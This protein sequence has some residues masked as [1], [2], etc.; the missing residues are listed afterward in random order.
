MSRGTDLNV[1]LGVDIDPF[2]Q[3]LRESLR[4]A[5]GTGKKMEKAVEEAVDTFMGHMEKLASANTFEAA[6]RQLKE[7][8]VSMDQ[9]GLK[10]T[11]IYDELIAQAGSY[12]QLNKEINQEI[13]AHALSS[14]W[15]GVVAGLSATATGLTIV[16]GGLN[17]IGIEG[18]NATK[19][20]LEIESVM[21][22]TQGLKGLKTLKQEFQVLG[23]A[24]KANPIFFVAAAIAAVTIAAYKL[25]QQLDDNYQAQ[26]RLNEINNKAADSIQNEVTEM[27]NLLSV[28]K[29]ETVSRRLRQK[30]IDELQR[31]YP[32]YLKNINLENIGSQKTALSINAVTA[33]LMNKAK[34]TVVQQELNEAIKEERDLQNGIDND[35]WA[36]D[37]GKW[38][39]RGFTHASTALASTRKKIAGLKAEL[40]DLTVEG[41]IN[42][43]KLEPYRE[44]K[45]KKTKKEKDEPTPFDLDL[46]KLESV[47][48]GAARIAKEAYLQGK[49]DKEELDQILLIN[50]IDK[51][52]KMRE[53]NIQYKKDTTEL[54]DEILESKL[55]LYDLQEKA[56]IKA[57]KAAAKAAKDSNDIIMLSM[58]KTSSKVVED[59]HSKHVA[60]SG[61]LQGTTNSLMDELARNYIDF[62]TNGGNLNEMWKNTLLSG[63]ADFLT[64]MGKLMITAGITKDLFDKAMVT[65][66]GGLSAAAAGTGLLLAGTAMKSAMAKKMAAVPLSEG[67]VMR[68]TTYAMMAEYP[69]AN[70]DPEVALRS[71]HLTKLIEKAVGGKAGTIEFRATAR[72]LYILVKQGEKDYLRG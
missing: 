22:F 34:A 69:T 70:I 53:L 23:A 43:S 52:N 41:E 50:E 27:E 18:E 26:K 62:S 51:L 67:G 63:F 40:A 35:N 7:L 45:K 68:G 57:A 64:N 47:Y 71:S 60:F 28:A 38:I 2:K 49:H 42:F 61:L 11:A 21:A 14:S 1:A 58:T 66:G 10:G 59:S 29:D 37:F 72:E 56:A 24:I 15:D 9:M 36:V 25:S 65:F 44:P 4:E 3:A 33:A 46:E 48:N 31:L 55:R 16:K 8:I 13:S 5:I 30:A 6:Q 32:A 54:D 39:A 19:A 12:K 20:L 17:L